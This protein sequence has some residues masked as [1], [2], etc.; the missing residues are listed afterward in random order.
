LGLILRGEHTPVE[1][2][3]TGMGEEDL[4]E[5]R[6][7]EE[8]IELVQR[9]RRS[10]SRVGG[11]LLVSREDRVCDRLRA[12]N[13]GMKVVSSLQI[14]GSMFDDAIREVLMSATTRRKAA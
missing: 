4:E 12:K 9:E 5:H 6:M 10:A 14:P 8:S 3:V 13:K 1:E 7:V 2:E 11:L